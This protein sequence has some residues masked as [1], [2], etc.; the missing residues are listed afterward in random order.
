M[1]S[2]QMRGYYEKAVRGGRCRSCQVVNT[3]AP[4]PLIID[5]LIAVTKAN[6]A[7]LKRVPKH[8]RIP[9]A[10]LLNEALDGIVAKPHRI[11]LGAFFSTIL[12]HY[13]TA[14]TIW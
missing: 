9:L 11:V 10:K 12:R 14:K 5:T 8:A 6:P 1:V 4:L 2:Y 7:I 13:E 3:G